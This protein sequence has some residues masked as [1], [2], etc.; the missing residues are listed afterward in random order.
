[1]LMECDMRVLPKRIFA[2]LIRRAAL[3]KR[4]CHPPPATPL[5]TREEIKTWLLMPVLAVRRE[6]L[7]LK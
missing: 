6:Q 3:S 1:M 4:H 5:A 2:R 7:Q